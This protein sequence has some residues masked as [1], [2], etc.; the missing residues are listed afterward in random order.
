MLLNFPPSPARGCKKTN[1]V[2]IPRSS[3]HLRKTPYGTS[4]DSNDLKVEGLLKERNILSSSEEHQE[5]S[6]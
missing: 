4:L 3:K 2:S 5:D 6:L 1:K